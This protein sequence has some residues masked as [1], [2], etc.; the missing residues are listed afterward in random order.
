M[1]QNNDILET[2]DFV[3]IMQ[4]Y[5]IA[6]VSD[7]QKV[8]KCFEEVKSFIRQNFVPKKLNDCNAEMLECLKEIKKTIESSEH[9][10]M[11]CPN[12][13]GFDLEKIEELIKKATE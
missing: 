13:G 12:K 11:D 9:W 8:I 5:R 6:Q 1:N 7:Q 2:V 3:D 10:W 4:C